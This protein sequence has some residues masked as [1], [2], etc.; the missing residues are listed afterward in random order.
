MTLAR[1]KPTTG[2]TTIE[3]AITT[4][5]VSL[6]VVALGSLAVGILRTYRSIDNAIT[7]N[8]QASRTLNLIVNELRTTTVS[9]NGSYPIESGAATTVIFYSDADK[10]NLAERVRYFMDGTTLKRGLIKPTGNPATYPTGSETITTVVQNITN[11]RN[12]FSYYDTNYNGSSAALTFP[13]N[14]AAVRLIKI[15]LIID[16]NP[17]EAPRPYYLSAEADLRNLKDNL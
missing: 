11:G 12:I 13:I 15:N 3:I 5:I 6:L 14:L 1:L 10:D 4:G 16:T 8:E 7:S 2:L 9:A 17:I